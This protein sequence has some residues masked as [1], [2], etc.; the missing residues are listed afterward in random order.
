MHSLHAYVLLTGPEHHDDLKLSLKGLALVINHLGLYLLL[1][2]PH[3]ILGDGQST[4]RV[5]GHVA[6]RVEYRDAIAHIGGAVQYT[7]LVTK[8]YE[9]QWDV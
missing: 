7:G 1:R 6:I 2:A 9:G 3:L 4:H 5:Y 8:S